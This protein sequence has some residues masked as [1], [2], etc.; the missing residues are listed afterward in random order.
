MAQVT[1]GCV[2]N[3][4]IAFGLEIHLPSPQIEQP[5][6]GV[7]GH[8]FGTVVGLRVVGVV[9]AGFVVVGA[10]VVGLVVVGAAVVGADVVGADV[11]GADGVGADVVG[12]GVAG[13]PTVLHSH[14]PM[15]VKIDEQTWTI[16]C[17]PE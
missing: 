8:A 4:K 2:P 5:P 12:V 13:A 14:T 16:S 15:M 9:V 6:K 10:D 7:A 3:W 1:A 11:V 17:L